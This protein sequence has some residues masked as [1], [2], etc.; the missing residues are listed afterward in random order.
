MADCQLPFEHVK[1]HQII[2]DG[3][4]TTQILNRD[5]DELA[6][7]AQTDA[8]F[9]MPEPTVFMDSRTFHIDRIGW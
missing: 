6:A 9:A 5:V 4:L 7:A 1:A 3:A 2:T 8:E